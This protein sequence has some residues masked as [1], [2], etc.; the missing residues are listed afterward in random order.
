MKEETKQ[1]INAIRDLEPSELAAVMSALNQASDNAKFDITT[2]PPEDLKE[3]KTRM[4]GLLK[5]ISGAGY[6]VWHSESDD[7]L[8]ITRT[9]LTV[10]CDAP[11]ESRLDSFKVCDCMS[12][13]DVPTMANDSYQFVTDEAYNSL[14]P[15]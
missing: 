7:R 9:G 13:V 1:I 5:D 10:A 14:K 8:Y 2:N 15:C 11:F 4:D 12:R 6:T 3:F